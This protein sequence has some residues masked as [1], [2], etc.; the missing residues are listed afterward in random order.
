MKSFWHLWWQL[1]CTG[2]TWCEVLTGEYS[3]IS[4]PGTGQTTYQSNADCEW[5]IA[6]TGVTQITLKFGLFSTQKDADFVRVFECTSITCTSMRE[7]GVLSGTYS[8]MPSLTSNTGFMRVTFTSDANITA[9]GFSATWVC[10]PCTSLLQSMFTSRPSGQTYQP[11][12]MHMSASGNPKDTKYL[13][14]T[15]SKHTW[16]FT[17]L[18]CTWTFIWL[19][20]IEREIIF[21]TTL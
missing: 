12:D 2:C 1:K 13:S 21:F 9:A 18:Y 17:D 6:P 19:I 5:I 14:S 3:S 4:I 16:L 15:T 8:S 20:N 10:T 11:A 7:L